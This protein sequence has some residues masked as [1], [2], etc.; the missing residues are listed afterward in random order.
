MTDHLSPESRALLDLAR[1]AHD[2]TPSD[3][4]RV[5]AAVMASIAASAAAAGTAEAASSSSAAASSAGLG[6]GAKVGLAALAAGAIVTGAIVLS[7]PNPTSEP[8]QA[9]ITTPVAQ[10]AVVDRVD[11]PAP[12][13]EAPVVE[14]AAEPAPEPVKKARVAPKKARPAPAPAPA[15]KSTLAEEAKVLVKVRVALRDGRHEDVLTL[16]SAYAEKYPSGALLEEALAAK[17]LA[18]C[19][20]GRATEAAQAK[21]DL[22]DHAPRSAHLARINRAC[23]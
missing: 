21:A 1:D 18:L 2:P 19:E 4:T 5:K 13:I 12:A 9:P 10:P 16:A 3:K 17:V 20:L 23:Q 6:V 11:E 22:V 14:K 15:P 8:T 7:G